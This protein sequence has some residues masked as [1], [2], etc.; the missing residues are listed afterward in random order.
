MDFSFIRM[1]L[2]FFANAYSGYVNWTIISY[3]TNPCQNEALTFLGV[4]VRRRMPR[5]RLPVRPMFV[6]VLRGF[7]MN[8]RLFQIFFVAS[9]GKI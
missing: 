8:Q 6:G 1:W 7:A 5:V 4:A 9:S 3:I 2:T